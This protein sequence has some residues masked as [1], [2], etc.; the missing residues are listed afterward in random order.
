MSD[1]KCFICGKPA[2]RM[3]FILGGGMPYVCKEHE[4]VE[5]G[6]GE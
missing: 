3:L 6:V 4:R 2:T 5:E 1:K